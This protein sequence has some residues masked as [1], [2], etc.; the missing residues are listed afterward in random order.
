M[1]RLSLALAFVLSGCGLAGAPMA[2]ISREAAV[3]ADS[4][5]SV[6]TPR[7]RERV[8]GWYRAWTDALASARAGG[9]AEAIM[10]EGALLDPLAALPDAQM[11]AG[12]Y[13]CRVV[14][15]GSAVRSLMSPIPAFAAASRRSR[16][17]S[18]LP[19]STGHSGR[20][21]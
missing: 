21:G 4:W 12:D 5:R 19:S 2:H 3:T 9:H 15:L 13:D 8:R 7:D 1:I 18:A 10:R 16:L 20:P 14:K 6:A 17:F 11:P